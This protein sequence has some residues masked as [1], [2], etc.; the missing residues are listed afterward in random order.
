MSALLVKHN[1]GFAQLEAK[2]KQARLKPVYL[3]SSPRLV[4]IVTEPE[5]DLKT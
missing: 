1:L 3:M 2:G 4:E 5:S